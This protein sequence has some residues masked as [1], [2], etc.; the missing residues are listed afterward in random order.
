[1]TDDKQKPPVAY[2]ELDRALDTLMR[3]GREFSIKHKATKIEKSEK[4][5]EK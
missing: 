2:A 3:W 4:K 1:M 5:K